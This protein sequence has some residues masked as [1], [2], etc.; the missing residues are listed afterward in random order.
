MP[1]F[2]LADTYFLRNSSLLT[3]VPSFA[4]KRCEVVGDLFVDA[5]RED[6]KTSLG[7]PVTTA[8]LNNDIE[9]CITSQRSQAYVR[10]PSAGSNGR[11]HGA[12][13]LKLETAVSGTSD[14][15]REDADRIR[16]HAEA[17]PRARAEGQ[18]TVGILPGSKPAKLGLGVPY[19]LAAVDR[20]R[21]E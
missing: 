3:G 6:R 8:N 14:V 17:G 1:S 16:S 21:S 2:R 9:N 5:V 7:E 19:F 4:Q 20:I 15:S 18:F 10:H 11:A 12:A 13:T